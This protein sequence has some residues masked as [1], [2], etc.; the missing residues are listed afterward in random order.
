MLNR[1][2]LPEVELLELERILDLPNANRFA[3]DKEI[4]FLKARIGYLHIAEILIFDLDEIAETPSTASGI[5]PTTDNTPGVFHKDELFSLTITKLR[6]IA[7]EKEI[8]LKGVI[9]KAGVV[10][11]IIKAQE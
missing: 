9:T 7:K 1:K 5:T 6:A 2:T 11:R 3:N 8:S 4:A 10:S